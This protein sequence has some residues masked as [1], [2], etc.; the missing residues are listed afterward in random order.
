M[1]YHYDFKPVENILFQRLK[2]EPKRIRYT[3]A[4]IVINKKITAQ[5]LIDQ[6]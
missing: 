5:E 4:A 3:K 6:A 2:E 1:A